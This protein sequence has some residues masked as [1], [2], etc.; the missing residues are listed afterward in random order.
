MKK[1]ANIDDKS[2]FMYALII[3]VLLI[4]VAFFAAY[5]NL[6]SSADKINAENAALT[7]RIASLEQY[8]LTEEQNKADT[9]AMTVEIKDIFSTYPGDARYEDG[10]YEAF[11]L[12]GDSFNTLEFESIGFADPESVKEIPYETVTAAGIEEYTEEINFNQ[13][14]VSYRGKVTYE[15]LKN[16]V[17]EIANGKYNLAIGDM[18]YAITESGLIDG[19]TSLSFYS[20]SGAGCEYTEPPVSAYETGLENLF[21][22]SGVVIGDGEE[23]VD[24]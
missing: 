2:K 14:N 21:G 23:V 15:G 18:T 16:M 1:K 12:H 4:G 3:A 9:E 11:N 10:I 5:R 17:R 22:V 20:V 8:Y 19:S 13:F 6:E 7:Q 24:K